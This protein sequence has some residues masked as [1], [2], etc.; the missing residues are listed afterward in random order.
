MEWASPVAIIG[1][2]ETTPAPHEIR[3]RQGRAPGERR[4]NGDL[5]KTCPSGV[6]HG[7]HP[8]A[9]TMEKP[10]LSQPCPPDT[11]RLTPLGGLG[12]IGLNI[13][14]LEYGDAMIVID[15]GLMFPEDYMLGIDIV[16]PDLTYL[17][18]NSDKIRAVVITHGHEDHIGALPFLL[19]EIQAPVYGTPFALELARAKFRDWPTP[20]EADFREV[21][22]GDTVSIGPFEVEAIRV[23]HS[24]VDCIGLAIR[25]PIGTLAHSGDFKIDAGLPPEMRTDLA[26][27][28]E[29]GNEGVLALL[30]DSTNVEREGRALSERDVEKTLAGIFDGCQGRIILAL[31]ASHIRRIQQVIDLS[32]ERGRKVIFDGK[33]IVAA[34]RIAQN[35]GYLTIPRDTEIDLGARNR[36]PDSELTIITTGSQAEPLSALSRMA[37]QQHRQL[38]IRPG[39]TV[40][41]SSS[42]I[43]GNQ[44]AITRIINLLYRQG[45]EVLYETVSDIHASGHAYRDE[46]RAFIR[47][48]KPRYLIP[49]HGEYRHLVRHG[50]LAREM[51]MGADRVI[52]AENGR[53]VLL[54]RDHGELGGLVP[55]GRVLVDGKGVGD[56]DSQALKDRRRLSEHGTI[57]VVMVVE[58]ATGKLLAPVHAASRGFAQDSDENALME[59]MKAVALENLHETRYMFTRNWTVMEENI[60]RAVKKYVYKAMERRP[61]IIVKIMAI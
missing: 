61:V 8:P 15:A 5:G 19:R 22:A 45:A 46:L 40:I 55:F 47:A 29:L 3:N 33:S 52:V 59:D 37:F 53:Q 43:P 12:E 13:M 26:R 60:A 48:V 28:A 4:R 6:G 21:K 58:D 42:F 56:V 9:I 11:L 36:F 35:L 7:S 25:T 20:H 16:I 49:I 50:R 34:A 23:C 39:D 17:K 54:G 2:G 24:I 44:R 31:F 14:T 30:C 10:L 57:S 32:V 38:E 1:A 41:F 51:G 18:E 27:F